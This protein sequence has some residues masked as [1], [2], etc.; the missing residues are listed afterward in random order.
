MTAKEKLVLIKSREDAER[1]L[2]GNVS[3]EQRERLNKTID[4][5]ETE[6]KENPTKSEIIPTF[7]EFEEH[8]EE[9]LN[10]R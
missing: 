4:V 1:A 2:K 5:I 10:G 6:L 7:A 3:A 9:A 8:I